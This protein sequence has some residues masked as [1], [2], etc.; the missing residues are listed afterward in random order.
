M[1]G[2]GETSP[3]A[4]QT[5]TVRGVVVGD[6]EGPAPALRGFYVQDSG[7]GDATTSDGI[8]VFNGGNQ[9]SSPS[10]TSSP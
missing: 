1:Q 8:F 4:G 10:A 9:T 7:D 2:S 5:R 3:A 6:H